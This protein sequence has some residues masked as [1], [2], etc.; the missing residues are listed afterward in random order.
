MPVKMTEENQQLSS[1]VQMLRMMGE[2]A[3]QVSS[4]NSISD[5]LRWRM[6]GQKEAFEIAAWT[7][8]LLTKQVGAPSLDTG[9]MAASFGKMLD[10]A[11][12]L[13][14]SRVQGPDPEVAQLREEIK[15]LKKEKAREH[16][17]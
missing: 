14:K 7:I 6:L 1:V 8:E 9:D 2:K 4:S 16:T 10:M 5:P 11:E 13:A 3:G 12:A 15:R 17:G